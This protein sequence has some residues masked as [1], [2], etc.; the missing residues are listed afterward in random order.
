MIIELA[1][2]STGAIVTLYFVV[3]TRTEEHKKRQRM[4]EQIN[5]EQVETHRQINT[6]IARIF[7]SDRRTTGCVI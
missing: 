7:V 6:F 1:L 2:V 5:E 4:H 3:P